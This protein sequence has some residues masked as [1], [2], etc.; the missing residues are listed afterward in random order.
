MVGNGDGE[1]TAS[2]GAASKVCSFS[3]ESPA[4][5][6][7]VP[8]PSAHPGR[9]D[10]EGASGRAATLATAETSGRHRTSRPT[11][12]PARQGQYERQ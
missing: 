5:V 3:A 2:L 1:V 7:G 6:L 9:Q 8:V 12:R 11:G 10:R 4:G